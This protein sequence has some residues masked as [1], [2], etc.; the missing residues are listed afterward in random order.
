[1]S[2][3][4]RLDEW[5]VCEETEALRDRLDLKTSRLRLGDR[6]DGFGESKPPSG[7]LLG[8][9]STSCELVSVRMNVNSASLG[10]VPLPLPSGSSFLLSLSRRP[11]VSWCRFLVVVAANV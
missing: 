8:G 6:T 7:P 4:R 5:L 3:R 9:C 11:I 2:E 1:M 10:L